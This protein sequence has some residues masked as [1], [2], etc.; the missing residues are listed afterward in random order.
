MQA[1]SSSLL[2]SAKRASSRAIIIIIIMLVIK[3]VNGWGCVRSACCRIKEYIKEQLID[4]PSLLSAR[5]PPAAAAAAAP[6][7]PPNHGL[8][9]PA[10]LLAGLI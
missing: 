7:L 9:G 1:Q 4:V 3:H 5:G 6:P 10:A 2:S 8:T